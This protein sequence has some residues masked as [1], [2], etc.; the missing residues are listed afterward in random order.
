[1]RGLPPSRWIVTPFVGARAPARIRV[2]IP[3][4]PRPR[5]LDGW[6]EAYHSPN[7]A[8]L[9][10]VKRVYDSARVVHFPQSLWIRVALPRSGRREATTVPRTNPETGDR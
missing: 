4:L 10:A 6:A 1:V 8:R 2:G 3:E 5:P 9:A 7:H